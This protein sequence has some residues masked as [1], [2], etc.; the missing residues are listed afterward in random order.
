MHILNSNLENY[1]L[2]FNLNLMFKI[3]AVENIQSVW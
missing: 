1:L 3:E 2:G